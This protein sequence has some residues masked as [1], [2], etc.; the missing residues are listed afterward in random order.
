MDFIPHEYQTKCIDEIINQKSIGLFL[1]MGLGKT[2][3]TLTAIESLMYDYFSVEKV[4][5]VAPK[6]VAETVW[7]QEA[8]KWRHLQTLR[9]SLVIGDQK[10]RMKAMN[11]KADVYVVSR[12]NISWLV[13]QSQWDF[14]MVVIDELSSF[15]NPSAQRF[16]ALKKVRKKIK[17]LV[18]LTGTPAPNGLMD[19][20]SEVYLLDEGERLGK[21]ITAYRDKYFH[22]QMINTNGAC[23]YRPLLGSEQ[24]IKGKISDVCLSLKSEDYL[25]MPKL[26]KNTIAVELNEKAKDQYRQ[27]EKDFVI[28]IQEN[29]LTASSIAVLLNKL[30]QFV[31]GA[32]YKE[33][34]EGFVIVHNSKIE[35]LKEVVESLNSSGESV[36]IFY[37][38]KHDKDRILEALKSY[39]VATMNNPKVVKEWN[40]GKYDVLL[41]HPAS[42]GAGLNLQK[43]GHNIIWFSLT[44]NL[45]Y[46]QQ[47]NARLYRQGQEKPVYIHHLLVKGTVEEKV[48]RA[49]QN[50]RNIQDEILEG[51]KWKTA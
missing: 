42:S 18:G 28:N 17:R 23:I 3:I 12:D 11:Q 16:K 49:L 7:K 36:I 34:E 29:Q 27:F 38:Y 24:E 14:D 10:Q 22:K 47:A 15:K 31:N 25:Q 19:L 13:E 6:Q 39:R 21:T 43:G 26:I 37:A 44:W 5:V 51:V 20:W 40:E 9:F 35:R 33:D 41:A 46:Y 48:F 50:K 32:I 4:L 30:L 1:D 8:E 45:E 2:V